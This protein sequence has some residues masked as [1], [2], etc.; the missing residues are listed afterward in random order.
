VRCQLYRSL[1]LFLFF[2]PVFSSATGLQFGVT[3]PILVK[4]KDPSGV[5]GYR[6]VLWYQPQS[7]IWP[8]A[9][10]YFAAGVG[11]WWAHGATTNS[12]LNIIAIA[13]VLRYYFEKNP[14]YSPYFE[15][16]IGASYLSR[17]RFDDRKLG[18]HFA[19][20]D[21]LGFGV[22]I[23]EERHFYVSASILHYSNGSLATMNA[24]ITVPLILN[25]GYSF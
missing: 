11:H 6:A 25:V 20:Q 4:G 17:T 8:K 23:G 15:A 9:S 5:H 2:F 7:L 1:L 10:V 14:H 24:G 16:S 19:F 3:L 22:A 21:E 13:P 12:N 18:I